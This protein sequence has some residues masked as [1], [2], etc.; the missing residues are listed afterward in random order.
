M[1]G[2]DFIGMMTELTKHPKR[3]ELWMVSLEPVKGHKTGKTGLPKDSKIKCN[4]I[5]TFDTVILQKCAGQLTEET[6]EKVEEALLVH[7][8][9][10]MPVF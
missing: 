8:G 6:L 1:N 4:Q 3:G 7:I 5:R 10:S 2:Y 9:I